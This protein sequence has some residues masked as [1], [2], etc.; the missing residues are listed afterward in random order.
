M[1]G[2]N[3]QSLR[4]LT[5]LEEEPDLLRRTCMVNHNH[6]QVHF[7]GIQCSILTSR[8]ASMLNVSQDLLL[9]LF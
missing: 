6:P 3:I 4:T 2:E 9:L 1:S 5:A 8:C 7:Q